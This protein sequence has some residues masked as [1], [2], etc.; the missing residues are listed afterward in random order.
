MDD[1][2]A[3]AKAAATEYDLRDVSVA[4]IARAKANGYAMADKVEIYGGHY[5]VEGVQV[6]TV[7]MRKARKA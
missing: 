7:R 4:K 6:D 2:K 3:P 5:Y 1:K